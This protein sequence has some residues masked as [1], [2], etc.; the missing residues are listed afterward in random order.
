MRGLREANILAV[1]AFGLKLFCFFFGIKS[2]LESEADTI[3]KR[4]GVE[5]DAWNW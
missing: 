1:R 4:P 5:P 2:E 3:S